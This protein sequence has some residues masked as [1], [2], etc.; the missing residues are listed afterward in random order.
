ME[1]LL[2]STKLEKYPFSSWKVRSRFDIIMCVT[3]GCK[4][5]KNAISRLGNG[6]YVKDSAFVQY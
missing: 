3:F 2:V 4:V 5:G 1:H 6:E